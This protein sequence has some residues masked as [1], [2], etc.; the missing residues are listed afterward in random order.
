[1]KLYMQHA[2]RLIIRHFPL[3][4]RIHIRLQHLHMI[5]RK[6]IRAVMELVCRDQHILVS[7][8]PVIRFAVQA[9]ADDALYYQGRKSM[10][11]QFSVKLQELF[12]LPALC[13][14]LPYYLPFDH[15]YQIRRTRCKCR[16]GIYRI[17][18]HRKDLVVLAEPEQSRPVIRTEAILPHYFLTIQEA[19]QRL[20]HLLTYRI[21]FH[22]YPSSLPNIFIPVIFFMHEF[23]HR[24][25]QWYFILV[26][27][28]ISS[29]LC[30]KFP[31]SSVHPFSNRRSSKCFYLITQKNG[32]HH[33][34]V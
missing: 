6:Y 20:Q 14:D 26:L 22:M 16:A 23:E 28:F 4:V 30:Q 17:I 7:R 27:V 34:I 5:L 18:Y 19:A 11:C 15:L 2:A 29:V 9:A 8:A 21:Q 10:F 3:F 1:M 32:P 25:P 24:C 33:T 12:R 13:H 31:A